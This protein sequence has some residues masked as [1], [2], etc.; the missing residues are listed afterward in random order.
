MIGAADFLE[1]AITRGYTF[2]SGVPCSYLSDVING[3]VKDPRLRY[4]PSTNEGEA[5]ALCSG[6]RVAGCKSVVLLQNSGLGNAVNPLTSLN[7]LF[8]IPVLLLVTLRGEP[9]THDEPQHELMGTIT[10]RMLRLMHIPW[11]MMPEEKGS[12]SEALER[13]GR[14]MQRQKR[15]YALLVRHDTFKPFPTALPGKKKS[16]S[17]KVVCQSALSPGKAPG[18]RIRSLRYILENTL[19]KDSL[20]VATTGFTGRELYA[21]KDRENHFYM[22]GSMGCALPFGLGLS[23]TLAQ[24]K[25]VVLDGDG[26]LLMHLGA[27]VT[28]GSYARG[29]LI[30]IVFDNESYASTGGQP[31]L[32]SRLDFCS[33]AASCGYQQV[34]CTNRPEALKNILRRRPAAGSCFIHFKVNRRTLVNLPRPRVRPEAVCRRF[35]NLIR[36]TREDVS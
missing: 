28:A 2:Y 21:I 32:S 27:M 6:A 15:P 4:I 23:L 25:T 11:E 19:E 31:S 34:V 35:Q 1:Q 17:Q 36:R 9:G 29:N 22:V 8:R 13:A 16:I 24:K 20:L 7:Y 5:V 33:L 18:S 12:V 10:A 3:I 26:A 14:Y 30:H